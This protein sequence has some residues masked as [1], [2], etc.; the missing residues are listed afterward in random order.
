MQ[1]FADILLSKGIKSSVNNGLGQFSF[2]GGQKGVYIG[3]KGIQ[4]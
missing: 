3:Q 4:K 2:F 1:S